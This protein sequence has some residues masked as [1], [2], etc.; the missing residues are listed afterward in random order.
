MNPGLHEQTP[1]EEQ[2]SFTAPAP[3]QP[4]PSDHGKRGSRERENQIKTEN[5]LVQFFPELVR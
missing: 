3:L 2:V 5:S 1:P 4:Q